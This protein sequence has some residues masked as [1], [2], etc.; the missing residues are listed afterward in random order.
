MASRYS[1]S[2]VRAKVERQ[3]GASG[4][5]DG[6]TSSRR[7]RSS[8]LGKQCSV[9][10][11]RLVSATRVCPSGRKQAC[12]TGPS[13]WTARRRR[14]GVEE[15]DQREEESWAQ[16]TRNSPVGY[17]ARQWTAARW[18]LRRS[19]TLPSRV[20]TRMAPS[21]RPTRRCISGLLLNTSEVTHWRAWW[22]RENR[23]VRS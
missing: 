5:P 12:R 17:G 15:M 16:E 23:L 19:R 18:C 8:R 3:A 7:A 1:P 21:A 11:S 4:R 14:R 6:A 9:T 22:M 13:G 20:R 10:P 2:A